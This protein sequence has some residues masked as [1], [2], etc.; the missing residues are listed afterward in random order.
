MRTAPNGFA[1][2]EV[3]FLQGNETAPND[4]TT[5]PDTVIF[6]AEGY[7]AQRLRAIAEAAGLTRRYAMPG[8]QLHLAT[9]Q[10][11]EAIPSLASLVAAEQ[12][13]ARE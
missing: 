10:R 13:T 4:A 12:S 2:E 5:S 1:Q 8:T 6:F 3:P 9:R 11:L 7:D